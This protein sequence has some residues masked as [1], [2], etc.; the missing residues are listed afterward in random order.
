MRGARFP[1]TT[2]RAVGARREAPGRLGAWMPA[3]DAARITTHSGVR[4]GTRARRALRGAFFGIV[5]VVCVATRSLGQEHEGGFITAT[6]PESNEALLLTSRAEEAIRRG[7]YRL[8]IE[9]AE[10]IRNLPPG[11]VGAPASRTYYPLWRQ[12]QRLLGQL[13]EAGVQLYRQIHDAEVSAR[14]T[15]ATES[16][17]LAELRELFH[18]FAISAEWHAVGRELAARALDDGA[19]AEAVEVLRELLA[20]GDEAAAELEAELAVA[21]AKLGARAGAARLIARLETDPA[22]AGRPEWKPRLAVLREWLR[23]NEQL[24]DE[25]A[26]DRFSPRVAA[27]LTWET[28]FSALPATEA[29][30]EDA[31]VARAVETHLRLPLTAAVRA[32]ERLAVRVRGRLHVLDAL[33][34]GLRWSES[35]T[36]AVGEADA[37]AVFDRGSPELMTDLELLLQAHGEHTLAAGEGLIFVVRSQ[38]RAD[39]A[40]RFPGR[41]VFGVD[42]AQPASEVVAYDA[43]SGRIAWR[44]AQSAQGPLAGVAVQSAPLV[45]EGRVLAA[46]QRGGDLRLA[47]LDA[48]TGELRRDVPI[49]GP[50]TEFPASGG[51]CHLIADTTTVFVCTGN[52]VIAALDREDLAWKWATQY[53]SSIQE[54]LATAMFQADSPSSPYGVDAPLLADELLVV[55]PQDCDDILALDRFSGRERWRVPREGVTAVLGVIDGGLIVVREGV[56]CLD[57]ADGRT[58]RWRSV[59]LSLTGRCAMAGEQLFVPTRTGVVTLSTRTG[60]VVADPNFR[61]RAVEPGPDGANSA[62]VANLVV[63]PDA[64]F[65]VTPNRVIKYPD[66]R[67]ARQRYAALAGE[68]GSGHRAALALA[69]LDLLDGELLS[70]AARLENLRPED[71]R[72]NNECSEVLRRAYLSLAARAGNP[73]E[74]LLWLRRA[75][76]RQLAADDAAAVAVAIGAALEESGRLDEAVEHYRG[77][78]LGRSVIAPR[79]EAGDLR[80]ASWLSAAERLRTILPRVGEQRAAQLVL[81]LVETLVTDRAAQAPLMLERVRLLTDEGPLR[82]AVDRALCAR[83]LRPELAIRY[84]APDDVDAPEAERRALHLKRWEVYVCLGLLEPARRERATWYERF[85]KREPPP[86]ED[87][88]PFSEDPEE[89][90]REETASRIRAIEVAQRKL[91]K[92]VSPP[93]GDDFTLQWREQAELVLDSQALPGGT[94][95]TLL[96]RARDAGDVLRLHHLERGTVLRKSEERARPEAAALELPPGIRNRFFGGFDP[97]A[98]QRYHWPALVY[99]HAAVVPTRRGGLMCVGLGPERD[100]GRKLWE[101]SVG[102]WS[103]I[104]GNFREIAAAGPDGVAFSPRAGRIVSLGWQDGA[105]RWQRELGGANV[106]R[107]TQAGARLVVVTSGHQVYT[108]RARDGD[109]LER[110]SE[111]DAHWR[112]AIAVDGTL[113]VIGDEQVAGLDAETRRP[114]W[115]RSAAGLRYYI[116]SSEDRLFAWTTGGGRGWT[117]VEARDGT[118]LVEGEFQRLDRPTAIALRDGLCLMA[119]R[120][121]TEIAARQP[122]LIVAAA[123]VGTKKER[124]R[125]EVSTAVDV[126]RS[127]LVAPDRW[128][129][130][131]LIE[132]RG[133]G[134]PLDL[135]NVRVQLV[136]RADGSRRE[137]R[138]LSDA[139]DRRGGGYDCMPMLLATP[140]R[141]VVQCGATIAAFGNSPLEKSK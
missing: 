38:N 129:P 8:A 41:G 9:L 126:N 70:A 79:D 78:L 43:E 16:G 75:A 140:T 74:R 10:Q 47:E 63:A 89:S 51:R 102:D 64:L 73:Q 71:D 77:M 65:A 37:A 93:I 59:P 20:S 15:A 119:G 48:R 46:Y 100:G 80:Q 110:L 90:A 21:L 18:R 136:D 116:S 49:V 72:L 92:S 130:V 84:L 76:A 28:H 101:Q 141:L 12:A 123:D 52:G 56:T 25:A 87:V 82:A 7:D 132:P 44:S 114:L 98:T 1:R 103:G 6:L 127:Q 105:V 120:T 96:T 4:S 13:P 33:T 86:L 2:R 29:R 118:P 139:F 50:P 61:I 115:T 31:L 134:D 137:P 58:M 68:G 26:G 17:D 128:I 85:E 124:W 112:D 109:G 45:L 19:Y 11:L 22:V 107:L 60:K 5:T 35:P 24:S 91:E 27:P 23:Q 125:Y 54:R 69:W 81:D 62:F 94:A 55:A 97:S 57:L 111:G 53:P 36:A 14:F 135:R 121:A 66:M 30:F 42:F 3:P 95:L 108:L 133:E 131:L 99:E 138:P 106:L 39:T 113:V 32:G 83:G 34:L 122:R 117:V 88:R 40:P 67:G 104:P